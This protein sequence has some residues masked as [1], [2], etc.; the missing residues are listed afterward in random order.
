V[1]EVFHYLVYDYPSGMDALQL[2]E[3]CL[4]ER[5][6]FSVS[7]S[8]ETRNSPSR[9]FSSQKPIEASRERLL[10]EPIL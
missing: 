6:G 10:S 9:D 2:K 3:G 7:S 1:D 4:S 5:I 8:A